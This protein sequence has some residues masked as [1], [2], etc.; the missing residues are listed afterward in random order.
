M[1]PTDRELQDLMDVL[2][3]DVVFIGDAGGI[4]PAAPAPVQGAAAVATMLSGQRRIVS[5]VWLNGGQALRIGS[6]PQT[7]VVSLRV[8]AGRIRHIYAVANPFE[9]TR[10]DAPADL[11]LCGRLPSGSESRC[12]S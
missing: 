5:T 4:R 11:S 6:E 1:R 12:G 7:A 2:A 3:P 10:L 8:E 9:V